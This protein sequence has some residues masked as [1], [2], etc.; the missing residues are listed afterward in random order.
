MLFMPCQIPRKNA[1]SALLHSRMPAHRIKPPRERRIRPAP[2]PSR[3]SAGPPTGNKA[4]DA[5][6]VTIPLKIRATPVTTKVIISAEI[7]D[8]TVTRRA[9]I[10]LS[11]GIPMGIAKMHTRTIK[12]VFQAVLELAAVALFQFPVPL[13][14][15]VVL[16][17][18]P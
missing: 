14:P 10:T 4:K 18:F 15:A 13:A 17:Q 7:K 3:P 12:T 2:M 16:F 5:T 6:I 9:K 1:G 11:T 8:S